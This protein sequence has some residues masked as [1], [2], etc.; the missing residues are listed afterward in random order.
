MR[1]HNGDQCVVGAFASRA[2]RISSLGLR[3]PA[4]DVSSSL[5][6]VDCSFPGSPKNLTHDYLTF[7]DSSGFRKVRVMAAFL[8]FNTEGSCYTG[9]IGCCVAEAL[10]GLV[11]GELA[12][13][14]THDLDGVAWGVFAYGQWGP[15]P[16]RNTRCF[17]SSGRV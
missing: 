17:I 1:I 2:V 3:V 9:C 14:L 10:E 4:R 15:N 7:L 12:L 16:F 11:C 8:F 5:A 13:R 6:Y